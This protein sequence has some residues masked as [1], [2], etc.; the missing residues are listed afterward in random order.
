[1]A[2]RS[3]RPQG[4]GGAQGEQ[5]AKFLAD[6]SAAADML[7]TA[8]HEQASSVRD[9]AR[10]LAS[11]QQQLDNVLGLYTNDT[12]AGSSYNRPNSGRPRASDNQ[13]RR[14]NHGQAGNPYAVSTPTSLPEGRRD[15]SAYDMGGRLHGGTYLGHMRRAASRGVAGYVHNQWGAGGG[16]TYVPT[17]HDASGNPTWYTRYDRNGV[18]QESIRAGSSELAGPLGAAGRRATIS[19]IANA[20]QEGGL[21]QAARAT[22]YLGAAAIGVGVGYEAINQISEQR[23]L[24]A[25]Y[26][27]IYG[28]SNL[29]GLHQRISQ[30]GFRFSQFMTGG[31][32]EKQAAQAFQGVSSLGYNGQQRGDRLNFISSNY[33]SMGM[34]VQS[35]L[36]LIA[37]S[38]K[39]ASTSFAD[40]HNQLKSVT[41]AAKET[42]QNANLLRQQYTQTYAAGTSAG[43]G[44]N[45][46]AMAGAMTF[47]TSGGGRYYSGISL[48]GLFSQ[49]NMMRAAAQQ[50]LNIGQFEAMGQSNL[51]GFAGAQQNLVDQAFN[52]ALGSDGLQMI[53]QAIQQSG[54][55]QAVQGSEG[56][57]MSIAQ[58]LLSQMGNRLIALRQVLMANGAQIS[59]DTPDVNVLAYAVRWRAGGV[60]LR[61]QA[62]QTEH[63]RQRTTMTS[64]QVSALVAATGGT[65]TAP[66]DKRNP[67]GGSAYAS[68]ASTANV[69][70][71]YEIGN[72]VHDPALESLYGD[73][74][75]GVQLKF[76]DG[77]TLS[78][79]DALKNS[80]YVKEIDAGTAVLVG[81]KGISRE[82]KGQ[83]V[84]GV[85]GY[86]SLTGENTPSTSGGQTSIN[87]I[88]VT[89]NGSP[90]LLK[91]LGLTVSGDPNVNAANRNGTPVKAGR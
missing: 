55:K 21:L 87:G 17:Q 79:K 53:D 27:S 39:T 29:G 64:K 26:Q 40:L 91:A 15:V 83:T 32:D 34:D 62:Q 8:A 5:M 4:G 23:A 44:A 22:P 57:Q 54:G 41:E 80:A 20:Y 1:M 74:G 31:L 63:S 82:Q 37:A 12:S 85:L 38:A 88:T 84:G 18:G 60:D 24:N 76:S 50:G 3:R 81:G 77:K 7:R 72:R 73:F 30:E 89:V 11:Q 46:G 69:V 42:G 36:D 28:G 90:D 47:A 56:L 10:A 67:Y 61:T 78:L 71:Q 48:N 59:Q 58:A 35:S 45:A 2:S 14:P 16:D 75:G 86:N 43:I 19:G 6:L 51:V 52:G 25:R 70:Q 68:R 65:T 49:P 13:S 9:Q 33:R 66:G